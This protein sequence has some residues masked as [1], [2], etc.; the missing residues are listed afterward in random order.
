MDRVA[1]TRHVQLLWLLLHN[2]VKI[3]QFFMEAGD[4]RRSRLVTSHA[5]GGWTEGSEE[6]ANTCR[7]RVTLSRLAIPSQLRQVSHKTRRHG[8]YPKK[9]SK[10][11]GEA[12]RHLTDLNDIGCCWSMW[13][14]K[15]RESK[16]GKGRRQYRTP[17]H[18][19]ETTS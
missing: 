11:R 18:L 10:V 12:V 14:E 6:H 19:A 2:N 9:R 16:L 4:E 17:S 15:G 8:S 7:R 13:S 1:S 3:D 5:R